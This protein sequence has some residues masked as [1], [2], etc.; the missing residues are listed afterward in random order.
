MLAAVATIVAGGL[1][2]QARAAGAAVVPFGV[3]PSSGPPGTV[4]NISG[5]GCVP[6]VMVSASQDY[7]EVVSTTSPPAALHLAVAAD[8]SWNGAFVIP[9]NASAGPVAVTA[10]CF[11]GGLPSLT[12]TYLPQM[13]TVTGP[14]SP[15]TTTT[16]RGA[17][18]APPST[19][20]VGASAFPPPS[21]SGASSA[22]RTAGETLGRQSSG[23]SAPGGQRDSSANTATGSPS[24]V[25]TGV[26]PR[27]ASLSTPG[28]AV[29]HKN[30]IDMLSWLWWFLVLTVAVATIGSYAWLRWE[31]RRK[32]Q[33]EGTVEKP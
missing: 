33:L 1:V 12:A 8:G 2:L 21:T 9:A 11:S 19:A 4:V 28:L 31:R 32:P 14:T 27:A 30:S 10:I 22:G 16:A 13:F 17:A 3:S 29:G 20:G 24:G 25:R 7:V 18:S 23:S 15:A 5:G 6:G 26:T